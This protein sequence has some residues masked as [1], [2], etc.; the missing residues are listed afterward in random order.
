MSQT[1]AGA[2]R[3]LRH[4]RLDTASHYEGIPIHAAAGLHERCFERVS[5]VC[6]PGSRCLTLA[7][8]SG[9]FSQR[10]SDAGYDVEAVDFDPSNWMAKG[11]ALHQFDLNEDWPARFGAESF[12][13][14]TAIETIE[15]LE[16]PLRFMR[17]M[18]GVVKPGG[19]AL[20][21][22]PHGL[23]VVS[24]YKYIRLGYYYCLGPD[25][26]WDTGHISLLPCW[27]L[28]QHF[29]QLGHTDYERFFA[30]RLP[31][32]GFKKLAYYVLRALA[33]VIPRRLPREADSTISACY[34][35][36]KSS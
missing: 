11:V 17:Q 22:T 8:G 35:V 2:Q 34:L 32:T 5:E 14:V 19:Y 28:E 31:L 18:M 36:R 27:L 26:Y 3:V 7:A 9:A 20:I 21:T 25:S 1:S 30:G 29:E 33:L 12:D 24:L 10:L 6:P 16:N 23:D 15:H 13:L 4:K